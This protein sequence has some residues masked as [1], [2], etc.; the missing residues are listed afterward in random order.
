MK[1]GTIF[2]LCPFCEKKFDRNERVNNHILKQHLALA[3]STITSSILK[4]QQNT[5]I[6]K[7][8]VILQKK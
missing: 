6:N 3:M 5:Y 4:A 7:T 1:E 2:Y 8:S